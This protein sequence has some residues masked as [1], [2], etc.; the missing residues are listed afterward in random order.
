MTE[1]LTYSNIFD[2]IFEDESE[3]ADMQFRS[4]LMIVI[5]QIVEHKGYSSKDLES[6]L[7][8]P[9]P[10]VSELLNGKVEKCSADKLITYLA[11]LGFRFKPTYSSG[12][13][14]PLKVKVNG[15]VQQAA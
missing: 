3:A 1:Q 10:R 4:D 13:Q 12:N 14:A 5:R 6:R 8:V 2:A 15:A 11:K 7:G 9:Q